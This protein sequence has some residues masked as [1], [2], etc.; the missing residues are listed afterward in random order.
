MRWRHRPAS[1]SSSGGF[2]RPPLR[3]VRLAPVSVSG[4][5]VARQLATALSTKHR[6]YLL[7]LDPTAYWPMDE[8]SGTT[9]TDLVGA[10]AGVYG[11]SAILGE[12]GP[13]NLNGATVV[14]LNGTGT[15][16]GYNQPQLNGFTLA[17]WINPD[18]LP[19]NKRLIANGHND[20]N[21]STGFEI[22]SDS[23]NEIALCIGNNHRFS[24]GVSAGRWTHIAFT[25]D[26]GEVTFFVNGE[27][28]GGPTQTGQVLLAAGVDLGIGYNSVYNG[29][30]TAGY[31]G[32][33]AVWERVLTPAE[34]ANLVPGAVVQYGCQGSATAVARM[35][36]DLAFAGVSNGVA[37][38][39]LRQEMVHQL[40][41][42]TAGVAT[43]SLYLPLRSADLPTS[44]LT[45][46]TVN[47]T[48]TVSA[49]GQ[50]DANTIHLTDAISGSGTDIVWND[51][52]GLDALTLL[53]TTNQ[54]GGSG[55]DGMSVAVIDPAHIADPLHLIGA[56]GGD[57]CFQNKGCFFIKME[58][59]G[60]AGLSAYSREGTQIWSSGN[61]NTLGEIAWSLA[62][63]RTGLNLYT[64]VLT[65]LTS[66]KVMATLTNV[67]LPDTGGYIAFGASTGGSTE[68][69]DLLDVSASYPQ[70]V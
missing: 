23:G 55:A 4:G 61:T 66:S 36:M 43:A 48:G 69:N 18:G 5:G 20:F 37:T 29:D 8:A 26:N 35:T 12:A 59:Y 17:A 25:S 45:G 6:D 16:T 54:Y 41:G 70:S 15:L 64:V 58:N 27:I 30:A 28:V 31:Y 57:V 47:T 67:E 24:H 60:N 52:V 56:A 46:Y 7:G 1:S 65:N 44:T 21:S 33:M 38:T 22:W 32:D 62:F 9:L 40:G 63:T 34:I 39:S 11:A 49:Y 68:N 13:D 19:S 53:F 10:S 14:H 3:P 50:T 2:R 42:T 51:L